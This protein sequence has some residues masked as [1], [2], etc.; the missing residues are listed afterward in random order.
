[1][2]PSPDRPPEDWTAHVAGLR[3]LAAH[4]LR[5]PARA[6]DAVQDA[7][8]VALTRPPSV[9]ARLGA[10]LKGVLRNKAR[11]ARRGDE[12]RRRHEGAV[13]PREAAMDV[14]EIAGGLEVQRRAVEAVRALD[15]PYRSAVWW[16]YFEG[17]DARTV[18]ERQSV[19]LET[20][21]TR[22]KRALERLRADMDQRCG[23]RKAW[24]AALAPLAT[25]LSAPAGAGI[26]AGAGATASV[27]A[28]G[29][30][31]GWAVAAAAVAV[32]GLGTAA[33]AIAPADPEPV[34]PVVPFDA[35][36][37]PV[38]RAARGGEAVPPSDL[39]PADLLLG[40]RGADAAPARPGGGGARPVLDAPARAR[41]A[42]RR[43]EG[44]FQFHYEQGWSFASMS[45]VPKEEADVVFASCAGGISSVTLAAPGEGA[46][47]ANLGALRER[48]PKKTFAPLLAEAL[49]RVHPDELSL[50]P[51]AG[52]DSRDAWS[53]VFV[54][55]T[56]DGD[57]ARLVIEERDDSK[58]S[59]TEYP[60][61]IRY[62]LVG[63]TPVFREGQ[64]DV[65]GAG[66]ELDLDL[67][68]GTVA[69]PRRPQRREEGRFRFQCE[70]AWSFAAKGLV[71]RAEADVVFETCAGGNS[72]VTLRAGTGA[73]IANLEDLRGRTR[74]VKSAPA[75]AEALVR[76]HP[77]DL[78][79][80]KRA[81]GD[82]R[83]A[84]TD[85]FVLRTAR[86]E[87]VRLL[88]EKRE[89]PVTIAYV[90]A[91]P[92]PVFSDGTGDLREAGFEI[93]TQRLET[94]QAQHVARA[95]AERELAA[96][97]V[98]RRLAELDGLAAA[99]RVDAERRDGPGFRT[100]AVLDRA[101][102]APL[103]EPDAYTA[104]T[105]SFEK[106]TRDDARATRND[107]DFLLQPWR[108]PAWFDVTTLT[109]DHSLIR[110][111]GDVEVD[112]V[113]G[114]RASPGKG[115]EMARAVA[116]HLYVIRTLDTE[117]D[118]WALLRIL[119]LDQDGGMVFAWR[120][121]MQAAALAPLVYGADDQLREPRA[122]LVLVG[123]HG[124]GNPNRV[125]LDGTKNGYV[126]EWSSA[127]PDAALR[128]ESQDGGRAYVEGGRVPYGRVFLVERVEWTARCDGD[129]RGEFLID[130][131]PYRI[132][133]GKQLEGGPDG[134]PRHEVFSLDRGVV[135]VGADAFP[136]RGVAR[137]RIPLRSGREGQVAVEIANRATVDAT[138]LGR[139]VAETELPPTVA[140]TVGAREGEHWLRS[141]V[142]APA[143]PRGGSPYQDPAAT[144]LRSLL[145]FDLEAD[146]RARLETVL[147]ATPEPARGEVG[148]APPPLGG[149]GGA[150]GGAGR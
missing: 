131:G 102:A 100:A 29:A 137:V 31:A 50:G 6:D 143:G 3:R 109:D 89:S 58:G 129:G 53:D 51:S 15:E 138:F 40:D 12:R 33:W 115:E 28:A 144:W 56:R 48:L 19:P 46:G 67:L 116:G 122:R 88:I 21:R 92:L 4:L 44:R 81:V 117:T 142:L 149:S 106:D 128:P 90:L 148:A 99:L 72:S 9:G 59:W 124:G 146:L 34:V 26:A 111:L 141:L 1:M 108:G 13:S 82:E 78:G 139:F 104:A 66:F 87:W 121:V 42:S 73:A 134:E 105:Y 68:A 110:D 52:G 147:A 64:G 57:W 85:V 93:D 17:L 132:A 30:G 140:E 79:L 70:Q 95:E 127:P 22:L 86:G 60:V 16:H 54:L 120:Y 75:L 125:F 65:R 11:E 39:L 47:I 97:P 55:R 36:V 96:R 136:L 18:A 32:V 135:R 77:L 10:W 113:L 49:V 130:V 63:S 103:G 20:A 23:D 7:L 38:E 45:I 24:M 5:D 133:H 119:R 69:D 35:P 80:S 112:W 118:T 71:P 62:T 84:H 27:T 37:A 41:R 126:R 123:G 98:R 2:N 145:A 91:S 74:N 25:G 14:Q 101:G 8:V 83:D 76:V 61:T 114:G 43:V 107:W 94:L 150:G